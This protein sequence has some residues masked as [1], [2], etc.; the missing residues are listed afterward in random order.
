MNRRKAKER[1]LFSGTIRRPPT[2]STHPIDE[3]GVT[4][5]KHRLEQHRRGGEARNHARDGGEGA[6]ER[7]GRHGQRYDCAWGG[8]GGGGPCACRKARGIYT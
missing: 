2:K 4:H 1:K 6:R 3:P 8:G 5:V 7:E